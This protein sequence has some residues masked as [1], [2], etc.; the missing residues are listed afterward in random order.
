MPD[1]AMRPPSVRRYVFYGEQRPSRAWMPVLETINDRFSQYLRTA[2]L[3]YLRPPVEVIPSMT[4][5]LLAHRELLTKLAPISHLTLAGLRPLRETMLLATD[6]SLIRWIVENRFGGNGQF[7]I[8]LDDRELSIFEQKSAARLAHIVLEQLAAA[9]APISRLE[10]AAV[11]HEP[12]PQLVSIAQP[13]DHVIVSTFDVGVGQGGGKFRVCIPYR[14]LEPFHDKL[15]GESRNPPGNVDPQWQEALR[16]SI[17]NASVTLRV[18]LTQL[19]MTLRDLLELRPGSVVEIDRP[20]SVTVEANGIC[21][22]RGRWGKHGRKIGVK[23]EA[24]LPAAPDESRAPRL[25]RE[26]VPG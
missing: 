26:E 1:E 10:P 5:Q 24:K 22:F 18:E 7:P 4:I 23:V 21:L 20:E 12:H 8:M 17:A 9:W 3:G 16:G 6:A 11:R 14:M 15:V 13:G 19:Q 25:D 2:L